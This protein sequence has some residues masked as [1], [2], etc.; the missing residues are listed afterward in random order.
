MVFS[1]FHDQM[2]VVLIRGSSFMEMNVKKGSTTFGKFAADALAIAD[3]MC[4]VGSLE[5]DV[6]CNY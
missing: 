4:R 3:A 2:M 1:A 5:E 6:A